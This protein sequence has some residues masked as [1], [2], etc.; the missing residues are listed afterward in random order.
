MQNLNKVNKNEN[1]RKRDRKA[2]YNKGG[3]K[4]MRRQN[5]LKRRLEDKA[6]RPTLRK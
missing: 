3:R 4:E 2:V 5:N 1:Q 6:G